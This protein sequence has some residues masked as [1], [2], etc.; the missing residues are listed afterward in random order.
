MSH[1]STLSVKK[2]SLI[3]CL[4]IAM[5]VPGHLRVQEWQEFRTPSQYKDHLIRYVDL[6]YKNKIVLNL[7]NGNLYTGKMTSLY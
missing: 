1:L 7:Y 4:V 6:H 5:A 3:L 2:A